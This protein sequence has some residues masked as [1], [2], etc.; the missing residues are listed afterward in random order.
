MEPIRKSVTLV[1]FLGGEGWE[2][3]EEDVSDD[4][5]GP[6]IDFDAVSGLGQDFRRH[7][8]RRPAN[9]IP[10][11]ATLHLSMRYLGLQ[12]VARTDLFLLI[13]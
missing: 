1:V 4:A 13:D 6:Y 2:A 5:G 7:V 11:L 8:C 12:W 10:S 9:L 3:A